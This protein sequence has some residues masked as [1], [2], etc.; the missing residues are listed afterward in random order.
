MHA[1]DRAAAHV[2]RRK[3]G[4]TASAPL[5]ELRVVSAVILAAA[6]VGSCLFARDMVFSL[7]VSIFGLQ[8]ANW[9][10]MLVSTLIPRVVL[11]ALYILTLVVTIAVT[12]AMPKR[13]RYPAL[14]VTV[15]IVSVFLARLISEKLWQCLAVGALFAANMAP[16]D[17]LTGLFT[18]SLLAPLF[19]AGFGVM[20]LA[21]EL[22]LPVPFLFWLKSKRSGYPVPE[23]GRLG[24]A[25]RFLPALA[26]SGVAIALIAP[27]PTMAALEWRF[28][29]SP[30]VD[31]FYG[32]DFGLHGPGDVADIAIDRATSRLLLCGNGNRTVIAVS[33]DNLHAPPQSTGIP[34]GGAQFCFADSARREFLVGNESA[35][36]L[37][38]ASLDNYAIKRR[39]G[40]LDFGV[41]E[42]FTS[43]QSSSRFVV[44]ATEDV[45]R[46]GR[47]HIRV[48][49]LDTGGLI[50]ESRVRPGYLYVHPKLPIAYVSSYSD[51]FGMVALDLPSLKVRA[52]DPADPRLDRITLDPTRDEILV[53]SPLR[54]RVLAYDAATLQPRGA[55]STQFG[56]RSM[57]VDATRDLL[58]TASLV[59]TGVD[60]IDLKTRRVLATYRLGPWLRDVAI[61]A[62]CGRAF[63][64]SRHGVYAVQYA[65]PTEACRPRGPA[66]TVVATGGE[67]GT[68]RRIEKM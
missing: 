43:K 52:R 50:S 45:S 2:V 63:V 62:P 28:A 46:N 13:W 7:M 40:P 4:R 32:A 39:I 65:R 35:G 21:S 53:A 12:R 10:L 59:S 16:S 41:G 66:T 64:S 26:V 25:V 29:H 49:D 31:R 61:D 20:I 1:A 38:V 9:P 30:G 33:L 56:V 11:A 19:D 42:M 55:I 17:L 8:F 27:Y 22:L 44:V 48:A 15:L 54:S 47:P 34:S 37:V 57:E 36:M 18:R 58:V 14:A 3:A 23:G 6:I 5:I 67:R 51:G 60:V 68:T 24:T